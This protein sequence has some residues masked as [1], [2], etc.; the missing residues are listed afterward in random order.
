MNKDSAKSLESVSISILVRLIE[1]LKPDEVINVWHCYD[2]PKDLWKS[3][4]IAPITSIVQEITGHHRPTWII[5][6][7]DASG[8]FATAFDFYWSSETYTKA[9]ILLEN[10]CNYDLTDDDDTYIIEIVKKG[11]ES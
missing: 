6:H 11:G 7:H 3:C 4:F 5:G 2:K 1:S 8:V 9:D 10:I